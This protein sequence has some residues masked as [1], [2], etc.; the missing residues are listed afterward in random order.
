[1]TVE[2]IEDYNINSLPNGNYYIS[3]NNGNYG[4]RV[5]TPEEMEY[6]KS[7]MTKKQSFGSNFADVINPYEL[8]ISAKD[9]IFSRFS[10]Q[11]SNIGRLQHTEGLSGLE[12]FNANLHN[13]CAAYY[14][15]FAYIEM[16]KNG[17]KV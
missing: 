2:R 16:F 8:Q 15:P 14:N 13:I 3:V 1:M 11:L 4:A 7:S 6:L 17:F 12:L 9:N 10:K 5:C